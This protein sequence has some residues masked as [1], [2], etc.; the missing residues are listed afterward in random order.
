MTF[1]L[2][3]AGIVLTFTLLRVMGNEREHA[4]RRRDAEV[5]AKAV[6]AAAATAAAAAVEAPGVVSAAKGQATKGAAVQPK[7]VVQAKPPAK[8]A[9]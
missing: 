9:A 1:I 3:A 6:E 2:T 4:Q 7:P 8:K 5:E